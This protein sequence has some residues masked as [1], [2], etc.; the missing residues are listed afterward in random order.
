MSPEDDLQR[1][2]VLSPRAVYR[3]P[4]EEQISKAGDV[5]AR[6]KGLI[7]QNP[8]ILPNELRSKLGKVWQPI[9]FLGAAI[10]RRINFLEQRKSK[11]DN[12]SEVHEALER[13]TANLLRDAFG[14]EENLKHE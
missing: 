1:H 2:H 5:I 13:K 7:M 12:V 4:E 9:E 11:G 8:D 3:T 14:I 10:E 6:A